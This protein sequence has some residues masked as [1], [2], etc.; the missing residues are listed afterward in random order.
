MATDKGAG[1]ITCHLGLEV[2]CRGQEQPAA[3]RLPAQVWMEGAQRPSAFY[4]APGS[5]LL[6]GLQA[7][8]GMVGM[9]DMVAVVEWSNLK[10]FVPHLQDINYL[11]STVYVTARQQLA[12]SLP[13]CSGFPPFLQTLFETSPSQGIVQHL[14]SLLFLTLHLLTTSTTSGP[15]SL[16]ARSET[17]PTTLSRTH[18]HSIPVNTLL[19]HFTLLPCML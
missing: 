2:A 15:P 19:R 9:A 8:H 6:P 3:G 10:L 17:A 4:G 16:L 14:F 13:F 7:V 12:V 11:F 1:N 5:R 18:A